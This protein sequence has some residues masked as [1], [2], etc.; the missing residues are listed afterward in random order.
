MSSEQDVERG[1]LAESVLSNSVYIESFALIEQGLIAAW[2][3]C[4][5]KEE[6][7]ALHKLLALLDKTRNTLESTMRTGKLAAEDL[8]QKQSLAQRVARRFTPA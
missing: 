3:G 7:E 2:R 5:D 6:R 1:R 4:R 8:R